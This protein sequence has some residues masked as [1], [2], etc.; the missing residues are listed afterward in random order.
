MRMVCALVGFGLI[1]VR[2]LTG[3]YGWNE[4]ATPGYVEVSDSVKQRQIAVF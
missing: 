1:L 2:G 3:L 4:N